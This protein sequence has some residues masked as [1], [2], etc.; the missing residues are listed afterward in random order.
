M[1]LDVSAVGKKTD[2]LTHS[3]RWQDAALYAL[4]IGAKKDELDY[5]Y[6]GRGP[7]VFPTYAV[8]PSFP[9]CTALFKM[10]GGNLLGVVHGSQKITV[11]KPFPSGGTLSTVGTVDGVYDLKRF[12]QAVFSTETH[13]E[14][15]DLICT[16]EWG[17]IFRLDGGFDGPRPDVSKKHRPPKRDADFVIEEKTTD[18]QALLYRLS[19][20][21]NPLHADPEFAKQASFDAP[22]LHG[23]C[24]YGHAARAVIQGACGGDGDRLISFEGQFRKPV[25]PGDTLVTSGWIEEGEVFVQ[26][27]TLERPDDIAFSFARATIRQ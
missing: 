20:D 19:G 11:H 26:T 2:V 7:K 3:Y 5:L 12:A 23:L 22:I 21:L 27:S 6:E 18:E 8:V 16:T 9:A 17:I 13:D 10:V 15:G 14:A 1:A 4:G 25:W 24:T